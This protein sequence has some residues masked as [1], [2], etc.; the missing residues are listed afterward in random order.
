MSDQDGEELTRGED[1]AAFERRMMNLFDRMAAR[2]EADEQEVGRREERIQRRMEFILQQE[3]R[4]NAD[5]Q[6]L[7]EL[8]KRNEEK[9][10]RTS[11]GINALLAIAE[12]HQ[13]EFLEMRQPQAEAQ[14]RAD[15]Q[16]AEA[17]A[18]ADVRS[19]EIDERLN[20]LINTVERVISERRNGGGRGEEKSE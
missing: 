11:D 16:V 13:R 10:A 12:I 18:R 1:F 14:A 2:V 7:R 15:A 9:W 20:A 17:R 6:E 19:S 8:Q 5:I 3:A 4:F